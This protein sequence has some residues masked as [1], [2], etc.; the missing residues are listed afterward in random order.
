MK[1]TLNN[2]FVAGEY[3][4]DNLPGVTIT[5]GLEAVAT[6]ADP[7][8]PV[9]PA[10]PPDD[11]NPPSDPPP[12][13]P[14]SNPPPVEPPANSKAGQA[15]TLTGNV[16]DLALN[17]TVR[18][19][20]RVPLGPTEDYGSLRYYSDGLC[21]VIE[22]GYPGHTQDLAGHFTLTTADGTVLFDGDLTIP[23][24]RS[25]RPFWLAQ[26]Q[27][28]QGYDLSRLPHLGDG[29]AMA[30]LYDKFMSADNSP[31][32]NGPDIQ[33]MESGG[34]MPHLG[35]YPLWYACW[36]T[37]P[38]LENLSVIRGWSD[39]LVMRKHCAIDWN[40]NQIL[41]VTD[42]QSLSA[43]DAQ[44]GSPSLPGNPYVKSTTACKLSIDHAHLP[45]CYALAVELF[46]TEFDRE[47]LTMWAN[48]WCSLESTAS[49]RLPCGFHP[50]GPPRA[51]GRKLAL[52]VYAYWYG[53][54]EWRD[55][56]ATWINAQAD[57]MQ[58][59]IDEQI[60]IQIDQ[61]GDPYPHREYAVW[62]QDLFTYGAALATQAGF[63][64]WQPILDYFAVGTWQRIEYPLHELA[65]YSHKAWLRAPRPAETADIAAAV[66]NVIAQ[67]AAAW[68]GPNNY[69][70]WYALALAYVK[71]TFARGTYGRWALLANL[72]AAARNASKA[73]G[74]WSGFHAQFPATLRAEA[75]TWQ[76]PV[77][78][79]ADGLEAQRLYQ[80]T[81]DTVLN[82]PENDI[83]IQQTLPEYKNGQAGDYYAPTGQ[84][85]Y[86]A[87]MQAIY[88]VLC[89]R[90]TDKVRAKA[91]WERMQ[92]HNRVK[93]VTNAK[94]NLAPWA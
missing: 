69:D 74:G 80:P 62:Q 24:D 49:S 47:Q 92:L 7:D 86:T 82:F 56:F 42:Y 41:K 15:V 33:A 10:G 59:Q 35:Y 66:E 38:T 73:A 67:D 71:A 70:A 81:L 51:R 2:D 37:N 52:M 63:T 44:R 9:D 23:T 13:D 36:V 22:H 78:D 6:P 65:N 55:T 5:L 75:A 29:G 87:Q 61:S 77:D 88:A 14:P 18:P 53:L 11:Q 17:V 4:S 26:P 20:E 19:G 58:A 8:P 60:G 48:W 31:C 84:D 85:S 34:E 72:D 79:W 12:T 25:T 1:V 45:M 83:R 28:R 39:S 43:V 93:Y 64:K 3:E 50:Y 90:A 32:G 27:L 46:G 57:F 91:A 68:T 16:R 40:T 54:P 21:V 94:Y 76:V 30:T 89:D